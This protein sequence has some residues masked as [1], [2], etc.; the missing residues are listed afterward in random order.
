VHESGVIEWHVNGRN[1]PLDT[2]VGNR[3]MYEL[4]GGSRLSEAAWAALD[5]QRIDS[6]APQV[7]PAGQGLLQGQPAESRTVRPK[8]M[9]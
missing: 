1:E 8:W 3:T 9:S 7:I 2:A 6:A 4:C 5:Q